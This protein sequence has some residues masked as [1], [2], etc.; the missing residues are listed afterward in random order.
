MV[1]RKAS[2]AHLIHIILP[3]SVFLGSLYVLALSLISTYGRFSSAAIVIAGLGILTGLPTLIDNIRRISEHKRPRFFFGTGSKINELSLQDRL[4]LS[5]LADVAYYEFEKKLR[6]NFVSTLKKIF[7]LRGLV[8]MAASGLI[9]FWITGSSNWI[10]LAVAALF[11]TMLPYLFSVLYAFFC[12]FIEHY[13]FR[14]EFFRQYFEDTALQKVWADKLL[15]SEPPSEFC[16]QARS[17]WNYFTLRV[18]IAAGIFAFI[19]VKLQ[20]VYWGNLVGLALLPFGG[21]GSVNNSAFSD[22]LRIFPDL[23]KSE[24]G[25]GFYLKVI[26]VFNNLGFAFTQGDLI[27]VGIIALGLSIASSLGG[28]KRFGLRIPVYGF[29]KLGV[30]FVHLW[31]IVAMVGAIS[32][33]NLAY[34]S[35]IPATGLSESIHRIFGGKEDFALWYK[36]SSLI[37]QMQIDP[38]GTLQMDISEQELQFLLE[39][40]KAEKEIKIVDSIRNNPDS[41]LQD[42]QEADAMELLLKQAEQEIEDGYSSAVAQDKETTRDMLAAFENKYKNPRLS[43]FERSRYGKEALEEYEKKYE[44]A[45][46]KEYAKYKEP[47]SIY[48][49]EREK[50]HQEKLKKEKEELAKQQIKPEYPDRPLI[51]QFALFLLAEKG[52]RHAEEIINSFVSDRDNDV[53]TMALIYSSKSG[54][55]QAAEALAK[56]AFE[57]GGWPQ[58]EVILNLN[59]S[60]TPEVTSF[61][62]NNLNHRERPDIRYAALKALSNRVDQPNVK[63]ALV[64]GLEDP[65]PPVQAAA[66]QGVAPW[67]DGPTMEKIKPFLSSAYPTAR[68][69]AV[70]AIGSRLDTFPEQ[71]SLLTPG[72]KDKDPNIAFTTINILGPQINKFNRQLKEPF[73]DIARNHSVQITARQSSMLYLSR[74]RAPEIKP[75]LIDNL[76]NV[77]W[78]MRR[79]AILG[80]G[81][82][83][84]KDPQIPTLLAQKVKDP[85]WQVRQATAMSLGSFGR[86]E[87]IRYSKPLL[88]DSSLEVR[89]A[90][91]VALATNLK[92]FPELKQPLM[93]RYRDKFE[94]KWTRY[95]AKM[96]V[97]SAGYSGPEPDL[98]GLENNDVLS[99]KWY[100]NWGGPGHVNG[101]TGRWTEDMRFPQKGEPGFVEPINARDWAYYYHDVDLY[102]A[103]LIADPQARKQARRF[104]DQVLAASLKVLKDKYGATLREEILFGNPF[105]SPNNSEAKF[106]GANAQIPANLSL[107]GKDKLAQD[108]PGKSDWLNQESGR[109]QINAFRDTVIGISP[110]GPVYSL[111]SLVETMNKMSSAET[112]DD[113]INATRGTPAWHLGAAVKILNDI[114]IPK[115][116]GQSARSVP[117]LNQFT[118]QNLN[119]PFSTYNSGRQL[120]Q[121]VPGV[122]RFKSGSTY[123]TNNQFTARQF[124]AFPNIQAPS[125]NSW[126]NQS[127]QS[128]TKIPSIPKFSYKPPP[129]VLFKMPAPINSFQRP[130]LYKPPVWQQPRYKPLPTAP[131]MFT[132][133]KAPTFRT[134]SFSAPRL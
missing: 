119:S 33:W 25:Y 91:V 32:P 52:T 112:P 29:T 123:R 11:A 47:L 16:L 132:A 48:E 44:E 49:L 105:T 84:F 102:D 83:K 80:L 93:E 129:P 50:Q 12:S 53:R 66:I 94:D 111:G 59:D 103:G 13:K 104:A 106:T 8:L 79:A 90:G 127:F 9:T 36:A 89:R 82:G 55:Q 87:T 17:S 115:T 77:N 101:K 116:I 126:N 27:R 76:N 120:A 65:S 3:L 20:I 42:K 46:Q 117:N 96:S 18:P 26:S 41:T 31:L 61:L 23:L 68:L 63:D 81:L 134:P 69:A 108:E 14:S 40:F 64:A 4:I 128:V 24:S 15:E 28:I 122:D 45:Y 54:N 118:S 56:V 58:P 92:K 107:L 86:R 70:E 51:R 88:N 99:F 5:R 100:G 114:E 37:R 21:F 110:I 133:P 1:N 30:N 72:L 57:Q 2:L 95:I 113:F 78:E 85:Q 130:Q 35:Q 62:F 67:A 38:A 75:L 124:K 125:V 109:A 19:L 98:E 131:P 60:K 43:L 22:I 73:M 97:K 34:A 39:Q 74:I 121:P 71:L 6:P 10:V 7:S